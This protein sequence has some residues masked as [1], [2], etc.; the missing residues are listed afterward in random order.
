MYQLGDL[1]YGKRVDRAGIWNQ[2]NGTK[3]LIIGNHDFS[4]GTMDLDWESISHLA[5][6]AIDGVSIVMCHY[7]LLEWRGFYRQSRHLFGHVH[8][9]KIGVPGS[10]DVGVDVWDFTPITWSQAEA[11][12]E[13]DI[14]QHLSQH[15]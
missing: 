14:Q 9:T 8:G 2:L 3:H 10:T 13:A 7:P 11:S 5:E 12:I 4:G 6:V 15:G 1:F